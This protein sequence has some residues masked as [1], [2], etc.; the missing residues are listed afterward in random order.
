MSRYHVTLTN[1][2]MREALTEWVQN[3]L[4]PHRTIG[5]VVYFT[6]DLLT[7]MTTLE[8]SQPLPLDE[9]IEGAAV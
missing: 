7:G 9:D 1:R 8:L 6:H 5:E 4:F 2:E 3:H